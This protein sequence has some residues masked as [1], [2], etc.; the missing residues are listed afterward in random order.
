MTSKKINY[1]NL[2]FV[3]IFWKNNSWKAHLSK[4]SNVGQIVACEYSRFSLLLSAKDVS[5]G[6]KSLAARSKE[7]CLGDASPVLL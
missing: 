5:S 2:E 1:W 6:R 7:N 4:S 3:G